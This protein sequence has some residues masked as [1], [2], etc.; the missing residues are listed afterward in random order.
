M[1]PCDAASII[2]PMIEVPPTLMPSLVTVMAT[3]KVSTVCTNRAEARACS[4]F[5]FCISKFLERV[6]DTV[7]HGSAAR[8]WL[9]D[10]GYDPVYGARPLKRVIQNALQNELAEMLLAGDIGDGQSVEVSAGADGLL[11]GNRV[12]KSNRPPPADAVVH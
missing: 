6:S 4:P 5:L 11:I 7:N 12:A 1:Q 10:E 3:L 8:T 2:N 9:A